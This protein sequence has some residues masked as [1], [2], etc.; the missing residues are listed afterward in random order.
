MRLERYEVIEVE[1]DRTPFT[2]SLF[3]RLPRLKL[4]VTTG[5]VNW[6]IDLNVAKERGVTVCY[7]GGIPGGAPELTWGLLLALS[8]RIA[9]DHAHVRA[10]G[11][12]TAPGMGVTGR[13]LGLLGLGISAGR[14]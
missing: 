12:Q 6:L 4:L 3:D 10:G 8:R 1:R 5:G 11:W 9:W 2:R 14:W 13:P 7:S